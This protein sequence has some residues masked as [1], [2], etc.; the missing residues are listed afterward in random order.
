MDETT[1]PT[2][3]PITD[4]AHTGTT[5]PSETSKNIIVSNRSTLKDPMMA[6]TDSPALIPEKEEKEAEDPK[7]D[8]I[9]AEGATIEPIEKDEAENQSEDKPD[10]K[11][12]IAPATDKPA[13]DKPVEENSKEPDYDLVPE[14]AKATDQQSADDTDK[15]LQAEAEQKAAHEAEVQKLVDSK[16]YY[17]DMKVTT[18]EKK[19][20]KQFI[21]IG[22]VLS[23]ALLLIWFDIALDAGIIHAG[24]LK[25]LTHFFS[26]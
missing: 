20:T 21:L 16:D 17:L 1:K 22:V 24:G 19:H 13:E 3:K 5:L 7:P 10:D 26:S 12:E 25:S 9:S 18:A 4:V 15:I 2:P 6:G 23:V 8:E 11:P 14:S